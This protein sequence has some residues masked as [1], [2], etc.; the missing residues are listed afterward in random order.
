MFNVLDLPITAMMLKKNPLCVETIKRLRRYVGNTKNWKFS[1]EDKRVFQAK[2][3]KIRKEAI[4]IYNSFKVTIDLVI[5]S[6]I[7]F[8]I[9]LRQFVSVFVMF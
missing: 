8:F 1:E 5:I 2:T 9:L 7:S 3:E 6:N 4:E